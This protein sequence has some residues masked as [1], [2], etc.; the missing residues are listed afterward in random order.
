MEIIEG[1]TNNFD[2]LISEGNILAYFY[3]DWCGSCKMISIELDKIKGSVQIVKINVD[4]NKSLCKR[5]GV[6]SLPTLIYFNSDNSYK[7]S[8]GFKKSNEI[9][10]FMKK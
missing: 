8:I 4:K 9:L 1:S 6:M 3:A 7:S 5:F 10:D 2:E